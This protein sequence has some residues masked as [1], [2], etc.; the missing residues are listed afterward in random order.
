MKAA[1]IPVVTTLKRGGLEPDLIHG[2][3]EL[4]TL[5]ALRRYPN[6]P[7]IHICH[8]HSAWVDRTPL[9]PRILRHFAVSRVCLERAVEEGVPR[10]EIGLLLNWVD[11]GLF[12]P[13]PPLPVQ[14][15]KALVFS[16]YASKDTHLPAVQEA[17]RRA[18]I[19]LEVIGAGVGRLSDHPEL[20]LGDYD[21]VFAK[22]KAALEALA[23]GTAV[24]LCDYAGAGPLVTL[25]NLDELLPLNFGFEALKD[26][27][28]PETLLAQIARYD[29]QDA[30]KVRDR[31][32]SCAGL[33]GA[34]ENLVRIYGE[35]LAAHR[36][37]TQGQEVFP[38]NL[39][40]NLWLHSRYFW[41][42][43]CG[44][45]LAGRLL[46]RLV[47]RGLMRTIHGRLRQALTMAAKDS[48]R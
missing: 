43:A 42:C 32:R 29:A 8:D 21:L 33:Q 23:V 36:E 5:A 15:K 39:E 19:Q 2:H 38:P 44:Q 12:K 11:L 14:P 7:A 17:C 22:A 3:H 13:R 24:I 25:G 30:A 28:E 34:A 20:L 6:T 41:L 35:T 4:P 9:H 37:P 27:L 46:R 1:G 48:S 47:G 18:G 40:R 26:P 45:T 16:N 10:Q 31:I